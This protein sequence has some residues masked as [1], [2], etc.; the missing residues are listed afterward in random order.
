[1]AVSAPGAP[2]ANITLTQAG[3][4]PFLSVDPHNQVVGYP[5]G[6]VNFLVESNLPWTAI[7]NSSWCT[8]TG[9]GNGNGTIVA[10]FSENTF[11]ANRTASITVS[12]TGIAPIIVTVDQQGPVATLNVTPA[13]RTVTDPAGTTTFNVSSNTAWSCNSDASWCQ[14]TP[15]GSGIGLI[16]ATFEQNLTPVIRTANIQVDG[17]GTNSVTV[18]VLQLPS[19]VSI[20]E[21][22]ENTLQVFP[23]PTTGLFVISSAS[24]EMLELK[25]SI[26]DSKGKTILMKQCKGAN[27]YT[28]DLSQAA[29]GNYFIKVETGG[30]THVMKIIVQ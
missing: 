10:T 7:S 18:Q 17:D 8:V 16:M 12:A 11:A 27:S 1:M 2:N 25:V 30:K 19:F 23:N 22:P 20:G 9:S 28:F 6:S 5:S 14:P 24:S 4:A 29:S 21:N 3:A 15:S 26:I 13:S